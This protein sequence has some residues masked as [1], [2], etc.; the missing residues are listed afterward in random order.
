MAAVPLWCYDRLVV[1]FRA[2]RRCH[3]ST[4]YITTRCG[5]GAQWVRLGRA[6]N[7]RATS[8]VECQVAIASRRRLSRCAVV[9]PIVLVGAR[10]LPRSCSQAPFRARHVRTHGHKFL[11]GRKG[12]APVVASLSSGA[13]GC[14]QVSQVLPRVRGARAHIRKFLSGRTVRVPTAQV[15]LVLHDCVPF[16]IAEGVAWKRSCWYCR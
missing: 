4:P 5:R 8:L 10:A 16:I 1:R 9:A 2:R 11:S 7:S 3:Q 14:A 12:V 15:A 6:G 13:R